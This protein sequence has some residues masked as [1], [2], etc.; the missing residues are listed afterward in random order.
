MSRCHPLCNIPQ[1]AD[2]CKE[3]FFH[4]VAAYRADLRLFLAGN[5]VFKMP[6]DYCES[7]SGPLLI[8]EPVLLCVTVKS[9]PEPG[10]M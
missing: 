7:L 6:L 4:N 2:F 10:M 9:V 8:K 3:C 5:Q 1:K